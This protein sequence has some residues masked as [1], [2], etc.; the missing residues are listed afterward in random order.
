MFCLLFKYFHFATMNPVGILSVFFLQIID[1]EQHQ[2]I[3]TFREVRSGC[4]EFIKDADEF[5]CV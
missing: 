4:P 5:F 3:Y 2:T 1:K